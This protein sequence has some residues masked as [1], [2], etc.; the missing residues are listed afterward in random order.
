MGYPIQLYTNIVCIYMY[1]LLKFYYYLTTSVQCTP[2][3]YVYY[4]PH[5]SKPMGCILQVF[6]FH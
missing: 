4:K 6:I 1:I 3:I 2:Y 5:I